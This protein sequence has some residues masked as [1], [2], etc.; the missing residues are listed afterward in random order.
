MNS[1]GRPARR[2][3]SP[4]RKKQ[5]DLTRDTILR[6]LVDEVAR[7]R[8]GEYG[9]A[10]VAARA[11]VSIRT[12]YRHFE[13]REALG[14]A[15][16][17]AVAKQAVPPPPADLAGLSSY[18]EALFAVF[19]EHAPWV[20]AMLKVGEAGAI[21]QAGKPRRVAALRAPLAPLLDSLAPAQATAALAVIKHLI[22]ADAWKAMRDD[23]GLDGRAAGRAV[24][25]AVRVLLDE[26][27]R[28]KGPS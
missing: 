23:F 8:P 1:R 9:L 22:S 25:W 21:R 2:Y 17:A 18:P 5:A 14:V 3:R 26:L 6:A 11:G 13:S 16:E 12:L 15:L 19:D 4:L 24:G 27:K 20:E 10:E 7:S 28:K